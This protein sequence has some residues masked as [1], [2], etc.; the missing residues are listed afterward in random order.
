MNDDLGY[1]ADRLNSAIAKAE[2]AIFNLN[3]GVRASVP[4]R[5]GTDLVFSKIG[6]R[7]SLGI[8]TPNNPTPHSLIMTGSIEVRILAGKA[9][10]RL[11]KALM[12][13]K[14][15]QIL[16]IDQVILKLDEF[17]ALL[18][19]PNVDLDALLL[20]QVKPSV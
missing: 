1:A 7:W 12:V 13:E 2:E 5:A 4:L 20:D 3:L 16:G 14:E 8:T 17:T 6:G 10:P 19:S 11:V 9:L 15:C 18:S